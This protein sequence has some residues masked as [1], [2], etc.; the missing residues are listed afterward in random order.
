MYRYFA[1]GK[2]PFRF[3]KKR[4]SKLCEGVMMAAGSCIFV[5][6]RASLQRLDIKKKV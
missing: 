2:F 1:V 5:M 3:S 6:A 4:E